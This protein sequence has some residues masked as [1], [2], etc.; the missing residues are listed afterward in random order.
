MAGVLPWSWTTYNDYKT[1]PK[2]YYEVRIAK[3]VREPDSQHLLWGK[4]VHHAFEVGVRDNVPM[5]PDKIAWEPVRVQLYNA[6]GTKYVELKTGVN[7]RFEA[8]DFWASD[9]WNR[10]VE[11]LF[12][13][14]GN[15]GLSIDYKTGKPIKDTQQLSISAARGFA[16]HPELVEINTAYYFTATKQWVRAKYR[17]D[18]IAGIWEEVIEGVQQ[19]LWSEQHNTWPAKPSGLCKK[20]K[21]PGSTYMGCPV[22]NCPHSENYKRGT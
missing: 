11:D 7:G 8:C 6:P 16:R 3:S 15:K 1:C 5:P 12:I 22:T 10:G 4:E 14:N 17:R 18:D 21:K 9:C 20:S 13:V 2:R 19:M